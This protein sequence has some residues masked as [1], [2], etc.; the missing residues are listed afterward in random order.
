MSGDVWQISRRRGNS[1]KTG[2]IYR[3]RPPER[4][5]ELHE[6][7]LWFSHSAQLNDPYEFYPA[8]EFRPED[9]V[10]PKG[11]DAHEVHQLALIA[12]SAWVPAHHLQRFRNHTSGIGVC[13]FS[14]DPT[15]LL[16]WS[17]YAKTH[18]GFVMG[19]DGEHDFFRERELPENCFPN[20][21]DIRYVTARPRIPLSQLTSV[22]SI[23]EV[24]FTKPAEWSYES[25]V[26]QI[27]PINKGQRCSFPLDALK[28]VVVGFNCSKE[29]AMKAHGEVSKRAPHV[30]WYLSMLEP[31][32]FKLTRM[33][34]PIYTSLGG[35]GEMIY[36]GPS[37]RHE[38]KAESPRS[39]EESG[40][41]EENSK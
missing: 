17:H 35:G 9:H 24:L 37:D 19:F 18:S 36:V 11:K 13:C 16:M 28:E 2:L 25:E 3:Y 33:P 23:S 21:R 30:R 39:I 22:A 34:L 4:F 10:G 5:T 40:S 14:R 26:R 15:S 38:A 8:L 20:R 41:N 27:H 31:N 6:N 1:M 29:L 32:T 12:A 7:Y